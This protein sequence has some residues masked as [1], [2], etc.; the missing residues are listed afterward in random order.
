MVVGMAGLLDSFFGTPDQT[1]ALGLLGVGMMNG[2]FGQGA[3]MAMNYLGQAPERQLRQMQLLEAQ[4][5]MEDAQRKRQFLGSLPEPTNP[6]MRPL[7]EAAR[8]GAIPLPDYLKSTLPKQLEF[9]KIDPKDYTP[10]SL[11]EAAATGDYTRLVPVRKMDVVGNRAVDLYS[12][13]PGTVFDQVDPNKPFAMVGGQMVPNQAFQN[14]ELGRAAAGA[15]RNTMI[16]QTEREESKAIGK[17]FGESFAK[18]QEAGLNAQGQLNR[19]NR[20]DQLLQGV[21][22]GKFAPLGLEVAKAAQTFGLN[23]DPNLSNKEAAVALSSEIALQLRNPSGGAGMPGAMSDADRNFLAG[24]VPGIEKTPEGRKMIL[25]TGKRLAQRDMDVARLAR[26]YRQKNGTIDEGFYDEL[27]RFSAANPLFA[28]QQSAPAAAP[29]PSMRWDPQ[30][31][32]LV[33]VN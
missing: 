15:A 2:G 18:S 9:S 4:Q 31:R 17:F 5:A 11:R 32:K 13:K 19:L 23:I 28:G 24:M 8:A 26:Q 20:L 1:R 33:P 27:A 14:Y 7:Y 10:E 21:D 22:T 3:G 12:T 6:A 30:S 16:N 29:K 25:E